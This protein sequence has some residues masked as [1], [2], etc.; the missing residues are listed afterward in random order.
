MWFDASFCQIF[1]NSPLY[2]FVHHILAALF[3]VNERIEPRY[4]FTYVHT[5]IHTHT[6]T[7]TTK[8][9]YTHTHTHTHK[10]TYIY[11]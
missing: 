11:M 8:Y 6:H 2:S 5:Y 3:F 7:H 10:H 4:I 9:V 1:A